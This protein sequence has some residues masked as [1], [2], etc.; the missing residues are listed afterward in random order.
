MAHSETAI[1]SLEE[2]RVRFEEWRNHR[3]GKAR[4]PAELWSAAVE[5]AKRKAKIG[6]FPDT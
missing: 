4:I 5:V 3:S 2:V 1:I 6:L